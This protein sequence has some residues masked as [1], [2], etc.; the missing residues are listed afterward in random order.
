V[1][2]RRFVGREVAWQCTS[3]LGDLIVRLPRTFAESRQ[4]GIDHI[5]E[6]SS[7][8]LRIAVS[9]T[10]VLDLDDATGGRTVSGPEERNVRRAPGTGW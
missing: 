5:D 9:S 6:G 3:A 4:T 7:V 1:D 2:S 10:H 8:T